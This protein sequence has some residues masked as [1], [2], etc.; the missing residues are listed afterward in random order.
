MYRCVC[1]IVNQRSW[2]MYRPAWCSVVRVDRLGVPYCS[3]SFFN[4]KN[5]KLIKLSHDYT[6]KCDFFVL[7]KVFFGFCNISKLLTRRR[8]HIRLKIYKK[9]KKKTRGYCTLL[10]CMIFEIINSVLNDQ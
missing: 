2:P 7:H 9:K 6:T 4:P 1:T 8:S 5:M 10:F 3:F